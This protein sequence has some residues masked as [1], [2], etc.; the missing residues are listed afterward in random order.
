MPRRNIAVE[1]TAALILDIVWDIDLD[2]TPDEKLK[3]L[4]ERWRENR[5]RVRAAGAQIMRLQPSKREKVGKLMGGLGVN[6]AEGGAPRARVPVTPARVKTTRVNE[7][8][9]KRQALFPGTVR[10]TPHS[11]VRLPRR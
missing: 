6:E 2:C 1:R 11:N 8:M 7:R 10:L 9:S 4:H 3:K 5:A